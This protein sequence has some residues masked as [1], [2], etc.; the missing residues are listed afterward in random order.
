MVVGKALLR[1]IPLLSS[2]SDNQLDAILMCSRTVSHGGNVVLFHEGDPGDCLFVVVSGR[3]KVSLLGAEGKEIVLS[4]LGPHS[5]LGEMALLDG[6]PRS[7]TAMT[8]E[9]STLLIWSR[10]EFLDLVLGDETLLVKILAHLVGC[11]RRADDRLRTMVMFD[12]HGRVVRTLLRLAREQGIREHARI[13]IDPRPSQRLLAQMVGCQ[14][15]TVSRAMK[16][17]QRAHYITIAQRS[18]AIEERALRRYWTPE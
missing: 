5:F 2:L 14:P 6:S 9:K 1:T 8:L 10:R 3:V 16:A 7:A 18:L 17:L 15:E 12:I 13:V 11:L 4:I